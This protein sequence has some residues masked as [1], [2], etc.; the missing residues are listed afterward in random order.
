[1]SGV[2]KNM[3]KEQGYETIALPKEGLK[4]LQVLL[5]SG[6]E[7][8]EYGGTLL[9]LFEP[10]VAGLPIKRRSTSG[11]SGQQV[12][13]TDAN[14]GVDLL[15]QL[16]QALGLKDSAIEGNLTIGKH[17]NLS[18]SFQSI[19]EERVPFIG[20][21]NFIRGAIPKKEGFQASLERLKASELYVITHLL[22]SN[23]FS[24]DFYSDRG[25]DGELK[26]ALEK[27]ATLEGSL[28]HS[29]DNQLS[30]SVPEGKE[31][32]FAFRAVRILFDR[33]RWFEFWQNKEGFRIKNQ[34]GL[35]LK[36]GEEDF[37][38]DFLSSESGI[39]SF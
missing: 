8:R 24:I 1:M 37:P 21:D 38:V 27:L 14:T 9:D 39:S 23:T 12:I 35:V 15:K 19:E 17:H 31:L 18:F 4:P 2:L 5:R 25:I 34:Q 7:L 36:D 29:K 26:G 16:F 30:L 32:A 20:L 33:K 6:N 10:D 22:K 13:A 28:K 3:L 11:L